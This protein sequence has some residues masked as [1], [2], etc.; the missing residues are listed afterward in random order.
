TTI[1]RGHV[2]QLPAAIRSTLKRLG[3][4]LLTVA[5]SSAIVARADDAILNASFDVSRE[6]FDKVNPLFVKHW[7]EKS[8]KTVVVD[9]SHAGSSKQ[10]QSILQG[11]KADVVTFNQVTDVQVLQD[12]GKL[13]VGDWQ[14]RLPNNSSPF[15][16][17]TAFLVRKG[18]PKNIKN[19]DD[20]ARSD[21]R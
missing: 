12:K 4:G 8:G 13:I 9:Q 10:A 15:Y 2:M 5:A 7:Q 18:N 16:S 20:L 21:V 17:T 11:M 1:T 6:L 19:W 14:A 3:I